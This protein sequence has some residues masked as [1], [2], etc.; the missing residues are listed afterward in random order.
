MCAKL[1]SRLQRGSNPPDLIFCY[2]KILH[3]S[4]LLRKHTAGFNIFSQHEL[5]EC[6]SL[7]DQSTKSHSNEIA[8]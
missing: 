5:V 3:V 2:L 6:R 4:G 8:S 1:S 7:V